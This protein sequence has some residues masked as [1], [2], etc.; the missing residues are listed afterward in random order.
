M[1][2]EDGLGLDAALDVRRQ[3]YYGVTLQVCDPPGTGASK[4]ADMGRPAE[5]KSAEVLCRENVLGCTPVHRTRG[6]YSKIG[7]LT[8]WNRVC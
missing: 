1:S 4:Q 3:T 5:K 7:T 8:C 6:L 2:G